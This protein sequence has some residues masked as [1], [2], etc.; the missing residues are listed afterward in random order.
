MV[1]DGIGISQLD[2]KAKDAS[3]RELKA[4]ST[5]NEVIQDKYGTHSYLARYKNN[6]S[7][8]IIIFVYCISEREI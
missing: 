3:D 8:S 5:N 2:L 4:K 6:I 7:I 1:S